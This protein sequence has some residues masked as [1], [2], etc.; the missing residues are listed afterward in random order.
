MMQMKI[1][2]ILETRQ[3]IMKMSPIYLSDRS[4]FIV[5]AFIINMIEDMNKELEIHFWYEVR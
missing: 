2:I 5:K 1:A 3:E 4:P